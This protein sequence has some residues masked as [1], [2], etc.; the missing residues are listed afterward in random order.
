MKEA[1][2]CNPTA[3]SSLP[4]LELLGPAKKIQQPLLSGFAVFFAITRPCQIQVFKAQDHR[5]PFGGV[6]KRR[7][8]TLR[9]RRVDFEVILSDGS[10][11]YQQNNFELILRNFPRDDFLAKNAI[12]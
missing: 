9:A 2:L 6:T 10:P 3:G 7:P 12:E 1:Q 8:Q 5:V 4:A 11:D